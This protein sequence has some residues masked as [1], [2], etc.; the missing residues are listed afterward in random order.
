M[1]HRRLEYP[2]LK[3]AV[4][5]Q[6]SLFG[7]NEV[8]IEDKA[9]GTQLIQEL[10]AD[11]CHG[12]TRYQPTTDKIM[13]LNSQTGVI[14]NG[15]VHIP[16]TAPWLAEY[17]HEMTVFPK[18]K[19]DDQVDSTAQFLDWY[20]RPFS[21]RATTST[22]ANV[23]RSSSSGTNRNRPKP[24][25]RSVPWNGS[26]SRRKRAEPRRP[27]RRPYPSQPTVRQGRQRSSPW[28]GDRGFES[29][30]LQRRGRC[31]PDFLS[32]VVFVSRK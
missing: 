31:E 26:P 17:L 27:L 25:G 4:R 6:L 32:R 21:T 29:I 2:A 30:F 7:A 16:E 20:K 8:L 9:S 13:R 19:H 18:G 12:V 22:C 10:I 14:E 23:R 24:F 3:R 1:F 5:E 11:G 28:P 15:F